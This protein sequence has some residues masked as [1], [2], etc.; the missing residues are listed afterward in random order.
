[1]AFGCAPIPGGVASTGVGQ[2]REVV[3]GLKQMTLGNVPL[4]VYA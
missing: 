2:K 3:R 4:L 1:M